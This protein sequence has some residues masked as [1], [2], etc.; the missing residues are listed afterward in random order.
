MVHLPSHYTSQYTCVCIVHLALTPSN[1]GLPIHVFSLIKPLIPTTTFKDM[2]W[3][4]APMSDI[5]VVK[6]YTTVRS[7]GMA[8]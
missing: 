5:Q 7:L 3:T 2:M 4:Q 6:A 1:S 8:F